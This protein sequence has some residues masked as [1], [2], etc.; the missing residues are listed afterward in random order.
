VYTTCQP[1]HG[2]ADDMSATQARNAVKSRAFPLIYDPEAGPMLSDRLSL[3]GNPSP[4]RDW[5]IEKDLEGNEAPYDFLSWART[6][7]RFRKQFD[8]DGEPKAMGILAAKE[9]RLE[10]WR[11]LQ[12][13]AGIQNEDFAAA[14]EAAKA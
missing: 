13:L 11:L 1:E 14:R 5:V 6:E 12:Q 2:V 3:E 8:K 9:D 7:G 4:T 10:N